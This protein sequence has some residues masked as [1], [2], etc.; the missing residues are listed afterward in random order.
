[1][2]HWTEEMFVEDADVFRP[3]L[4][5][6]AESAAEEVDRLLDLVADHD[7]APGTALDVAC[8]IGRHAVELADRGVDVRGVDLSEPYVERGRERAAERGV[9][10]RATFEVGDMR[11]LPVDGRFDLVTNLWTSFGY[12]DDA[13]NEA[14][15]ADVRERVADGGAFVVEM[16]NREG[17]LSDF[18]ETGAHRADGYLNVEES[19]YDPATG[20]I[21]TTMTVFEETADGYD[22][23]GEVTWDLRT[24]TPVELRRLL[25]RAGFAEVS[26][27]GGLDG[28]DVERESSRLVAVAEP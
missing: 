12:Y 5:H 9:D 14:V 2:T 4:E 15:A 25:E 13:T 6:R 11:D 3:S 28:A 7:V 20:R 16:S 8:G 18:R 22:H 23:V 27:Y 1:M 10:D 17:M 21:E 19:E 26:L 24:Y